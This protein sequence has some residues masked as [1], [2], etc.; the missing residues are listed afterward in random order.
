MREGIM[1]DIKGSVNVECVLVPQYE[2]HGRAWP[3]SPPQA[4]FA[5]T[6]EWQHCSSHLA[7]PGFLSPLCI[8]G[9]LLSPSQCNWAALEYESSQLYCYTNA[10]SK[11]FYAHC[12][13]HIIC[14]EQINCRLVTVL[15]KTIQWAYNKAVIAAEPCE[16][17]AVS[18]TA[19]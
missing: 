7:P 4:S 16:V 18:S 15:S 2:E 5:T 1:F 6:S 8:L 12:R 13:T 3:L 17:N 14:L 19:E 10:I 9:Q 11:S